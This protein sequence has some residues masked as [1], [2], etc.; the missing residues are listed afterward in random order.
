MAMLMLKFLTNSSCMFR[1]LSVGAPGVSLLVAAQLSF[2]QCLLQSCQ[3]L[4]S[5]GASLMLFLFSC[6]YMSIDQWCYTRNI[7]TRSNAR[8]RKVSIEIMLKN[9]NDEE[10]YVK[11]VKVVKVVLNQ[12]IQAQVMIY[13]QVQKFK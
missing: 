7:S 3:L 9:Y 5:S 10:N 12:F 2:P 13:N 11:A 4:C 8:P 6:F 1:Y